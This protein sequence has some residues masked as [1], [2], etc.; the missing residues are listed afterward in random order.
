MTDQTSQIRALAG[1]TDGNYPKLV[2]AAIAAGS[3]ADAFFADLLTIENREPVLVAMGQVLTAGAVLYQ[4]LSA[5]TAAGTNTG[6]GTITVDAIGVDAEIGTYSAVCVSTR[7][8]HGV[9]ELRNADG[10][11]IDRVN[12]GTPFVSSVLSLTITDGSTDFA[13][14]DNF[15]VVV[16][17]NSTF[18][19]YDFSADAQPPQIATA[20]LGADVDATAAATEQFATLRGPAILNASAVH[21]KSF[22]DAAADLGDP[23][24]SMNWATYNAFVANTER[25]L[26]RKGIVLRGELPRFNGNSA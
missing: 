11:V 14:G 5:S 8:N 20:V 6:N 10:T 26:A 17:G 12:V 1:A 24:P 19:T 2:A 15:S 21:T 23:T 16:A 4:F 25:Q 22:A 18:A 13:L 3:T 9:F 7:T